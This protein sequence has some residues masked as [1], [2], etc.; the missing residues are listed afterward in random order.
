[1]TTA[2]D[3]RFCSV[4]ARQAGL[5]PGGSAGEAYE[6]FIAAELPLPWPLSM[7][8]EPGVLPQEALDLRERVID[9]YRRGQPISHL[10]LAIAPDRRYSQPGLRRIICWRRPAGPFAELHRAEYLVPE[11]RLGP[12]L[13][14]LAAERERERELQ[15]FRQT[16]AAVRDLLVCTHGNVDAA[17]ARF[18]FPIFRLLREQAERSGGALRAWRVSHFGG[19]VFAPTLM[20]MPHGSY[21]AYIEPAEAAQ[22]ARLD[23]SPA[24]LRGCYRGW[25]GL[26]PPF[27]QVL[28]R[29]LLA[30]H[31]WAW[32]NYLKQ[33]EVLRE[34][35]GEAT[36]AEVRLA[37]SAP[38]GGEGGCYSARVELLRHVPVSHSSGDAATYAYP[39]YAVT[40]LEHG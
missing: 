36:W 28:E 11:A 24:L 23:G 1:M 15:A 22:L 30:R 8:T 14:I 40:R 9:E 7:Y 34:G 37:Y 13:W 26:A 33:G 29:E 10:L 38:D 4:C 6:T 31:G 16:G 18:G 35:G 19:H 25:A 3:T 20:D 5:D 27:L 32:R 2:A 17:C 39:Q 12:A 21:W